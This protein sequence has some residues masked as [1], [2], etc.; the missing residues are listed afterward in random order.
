[1]S[2]DSQ[3]TPYY[4]A[5]CASRVLLKDELQAMQDNIDGKTKGLAQ[6]EAQLDG[7]FSTLCGREKEGFNKKL[8]ELEAAAAKKEANI[9][10]TMGDKLAALL[11]DLEHHRQYSAKQHEAELHKLQGMIGV[12]KKKAACDEE[13]H[14]ANKEAA[15]RRAQAAL[16]SGMN[17]LEND[18]QKHCAEMRRGMTNLLQGEYEELVSKHEWHKGKAR[19]DLNALVAAAENRLAKDCASSVVASVDKLV[20]KMSLPSEERFARAYN[21]GDSD[22]QTAMLD[23]V[24]SP[25]GGLGKAMADASA[26]DLQSF[27]QELQTL[28]ACA[29]PEKLN[30]ELDALAKKFGIR[31][32]Q[33]NNDL[34][35][36][37]DKY[38]GL[39][40]AK[41]KE[42]MDHLAKTD[43]DFQKRKSDTVAKH[44]SAVGAELQEMEDVMSGKRSLNMKELS[45]LEAQWDH[46]TKSQKAQL[47]AIIQRMEDAKKDHAAHVGRMVGA[48]REQVKNARDA[49]QTQLM[50]RCGAHKAGIENTKANAR[51]RVQNEIASLKKGIAERLMTD[52]R[53]VIS[54]DLGSTLRAMA[55][56]DFP[57]LA[58]ADAP[59]L[60]PCPRQGGGH[61][62]PPW[63]PP[64]RDA[65]AVVAPPRPTWMPCSPRSSRGTPN[66]QNNCVSK[67][68]C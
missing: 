38:N 37:S 17:D 58:G 28:P 40:A 6:L 60:P 19:E 50:Q 31:K 44:R 34:K 41:K 52:C 7:E 48:H 26:K 43:A 30:A 25:E 39:S 53:R 9:H 67:W 65:D 55:E 46:L 35:A 22:Q 3:V 8:G 29:N 63:P 62:P 18:Y 42:L 68:C 12:N 15:K 4:G 11:D 57:G 51:A 56:K 32:G 49:L 47:I 23:S 2:T 20:D 14:A 64:L 1:M 45:K 66:K 27:A 21:K 59:A 24:L 10:Q 13:Q 16:N 5:A 33:L 54:S 36:L 61:T